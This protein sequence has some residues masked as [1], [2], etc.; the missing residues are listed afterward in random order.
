[1]AIV[2]VWKKELL[3]TFI[4][5][6]LDQIVKYQQILG[7]GELQALGCRGGRQLRCDSLERKDSFTQQHISG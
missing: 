5:L 4:S 7:C 2:P 6:L 3:S 1:M